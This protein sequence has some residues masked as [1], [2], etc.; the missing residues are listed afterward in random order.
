[1]NRSQGLVVYRH[2]YSAILEKS[3]YKFRFWN[4]FGVSSSYD[5]VDD[6]DVLPWEEKMNQCKN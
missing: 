4:D 1:M 5:S 6:F 3:A 2:D